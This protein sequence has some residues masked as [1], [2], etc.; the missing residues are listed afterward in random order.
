MKKVINDQYQ[1]QAD[2]F[3]TEH[4]GIKMIINTYCEQLYTR[5]FDNLD[6]MGKFLEIHKLPKFTQE[7]INNLKS[8]ISTKE[9]EFITNKFYIY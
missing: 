2:A 9:I 5:N 8:L 7:E 4:I 6:E 1:N 3:A